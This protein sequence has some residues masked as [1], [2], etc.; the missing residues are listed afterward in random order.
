M[1]ITVDNLRRRVGP[2]NCWPRGWVRG[3]IRVRVSI[4]SI[5]NVRCAPSP[6]RGVGGGRLWLSAL[7]W[8]TSLGASAA[9]RGDAKQPWGPR[10]TYGAVVR[11]GPD[12]L[13]DRTR[14]CGTSHSHVL[15]AR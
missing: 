1:T 3:L 12:L 15:L 7:N 10:R 11:S 2:G 4:L 6:T 14:I 13:G 5:S 9:G 8:V